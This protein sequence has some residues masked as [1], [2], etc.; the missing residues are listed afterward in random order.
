M[1]LATFR[2]QFPE[3]KAMSDGFVQSWLDA[4]ALDL[5]PTLWGVHYDQGHGLLTA[6]QISS[7][8]FGQAARTTDEDT[9]Y[10]ALYQRKLRQVT[11]GYRVA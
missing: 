9:M 2:V 10:Y 8:P 3:F 6:H 5:D 7:T 4:S 1:T 11:S